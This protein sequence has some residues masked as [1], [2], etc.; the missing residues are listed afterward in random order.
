PRAESSSA[1]AAPTTP[2]PMITTRAPVM[3][4]LPVSA[5]DPTSGALVGSGS[6]ERAARRS[7]VAQLAPA[8]RHVVLQLL[9]DRVVQR[10]WL[11]LRQLRAGHLGGPG[12]GVGR[13]VADPPLVVVRAGQER[14]VEAGAEPFHG[15]CRAEEVPAVAHLVV[16]LERQRRLVDL[17]RGELLLQ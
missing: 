2:A 10:R 8:A 12:R 7:S 13:P 9:T 16:G 11:V 5:S 15:V 14:A 3:P 6:G 4:L 1:S 17:Q